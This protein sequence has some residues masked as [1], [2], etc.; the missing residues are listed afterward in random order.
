MGI[1][2]GTVLA[3]IVCGFLAQSDQF[4]DVLRSWGMRPER[5]WHWGFGS[6]AVGMSLGLIQYWAG[7]KYL[8]KIGL[9][10]FDPNS[11]ESRRQR[12]RILYGLAA[13][14]TFIIF[15]TVLQTQGVIRI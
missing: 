3:P 9:S 5:S 7:Q 10:R 1:R 2:V 6:A 12:T 13:V 15:V 14:A 11:T 8:G 4:R